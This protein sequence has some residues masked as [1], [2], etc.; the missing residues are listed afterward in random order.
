MS[1]PL[2]ASQGSLFVQLTPGTAPEYLGCADVDAIPDPRG[3]ISLVRCRDANGDYLTIGE[4]RTAPDTVT[5]TVTALVYPD[6]DI[7][8]DLSD[9]HCR[10]NIFLMLRDCGKAGQF[11]NWVRAA[12]LH[13]ARLTNLTLSNYVMRE[14]ADS[15]TRAL[16][17]AGW[18]VR[19]LRNKLRFSRQAIAE[20][21]D[22]N[23][24]AVDTEELCAG[25]CSGGQN[26]GD[27]A[28]IGGDAPA[29]SV[30]AHA[31]VW[32]TDDE[33]GNWV[34]TT[35]GAGHPFAAAEDI[36]AAA[37]FQIDRST[38][39]WLV[40]REQVGGEPLKVAYSDDEGAS[41][42][43]A[44][45]GS[46]NNEGVASAKALFALDRDHIWIGTTAGAIFFSDDGGVTWTEQTG[47]ATADGAASLN[48]V[49]FIDTHNGYAVGASGAIIRT[50]DGGFTWSAVTPP[51]AAAAANITALAV[52]SPFRIEIGTGADGL[53]QTRDAGANWDTKTFTGQ[54]TTGTVK[55]LYPVNDD[56]VYMAH[57]P[58]A[59]QGYVHR[60]IDGGHSFERLV[61]PTNSGLNDL[62]AWDSNHAFVVGAANGG[63]GFVALVQF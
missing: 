12:V 33:G 52:F 54:S 29:G 24:I 56:V 53:Y 30:L 17:F 27:I 8:D 3:G 28:F 55:A 44:T 49:A 41:W 35:G 7:L 11:N 38:K 31:D 46:T 34:N 25:D 42:T 61:T 14:A 16:E 1:E 20:T 51:S 23:A 13:H 2:N 39:R 43:L 62:V 58:A 21:T 19:Q 15:A 40:A 18:G 37:L 5:T 32:H 10:A 50:D 9:R 36:M 47:A 59:G 63:T 26:A 60:S 57:N 48:A 45:V 4:T 6:A 22:L